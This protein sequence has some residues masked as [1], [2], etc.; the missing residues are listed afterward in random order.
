MNVYYDCGGVDPH[1]TQLYF[2][3]YAKLDPLTNGHVFAEIEEP[4]ATADLMP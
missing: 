3:Q 4:I 2:D 1:Y